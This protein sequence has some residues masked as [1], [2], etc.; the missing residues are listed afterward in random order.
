MALSQAC[1]LNELTCA[2][3]TAFDVVYVYASLLISAMV[4]AQPTPIFTKS[5]PIWHPL[6][7]SAH[8]V[9][10]RSPQ[11]TLPSPKASSSAYLLHIT[12]RQSPNLERQGNSQG[13]LACSFKLQV[14]G[15]YVTAG[16]GHNLAITSG[17][18]HLIDSATHADSIKRCI[19]NKW[20][21]ERTHTQN[22]EEHAVSLSNAVSSINFAEHNV[23]IMSMNARE[24]GTWVPMSA[25]TSGIMWPR[26]MK[27]SPAC[28]VRK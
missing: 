22:T 19:F 27:S 12:A 5:V 10:L 13:K 9:F 17:P 23:L 7:K 18:Q 6:N 28:V 16:P 24:G 8:F 20:W 26:D 15:A 14:N 1:N 21:T 4:W 25:T 2:R 11:F 3:N